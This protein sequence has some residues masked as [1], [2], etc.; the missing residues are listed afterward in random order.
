LLDVAANYANY[1]ADL[2]R[3]IPVNGR[4]TRRQRQVYQAVLRVLRAQIKALVPGKKWKAWQKEAEQ[5][6]EKE[7]VDLG[8]LTLREIKRQHPD[9]PAFKRHFM[10][11][12][13]HPLG[14]DVHDLA[15]LNEPFAP[16]WVMTI[17]PAIY[18]PTE[19]FAV[20]LE[21][22]ALITE[23]G[24]VDLMADIPIEPEEIEQLMSAARKRSRRQ[25]RPSMT[26]RRAEELMS[27]SR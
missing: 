21:N 26:A 22:D 12:V 14:L 13:G 9:K 8:L 24:A 7:L 27:L 18:L 19:G 17:E 15:L 1:N 25:R 6:I 11:G 4:F 20:R 3:T 5:S 16:G 23:S 10:H 2:T